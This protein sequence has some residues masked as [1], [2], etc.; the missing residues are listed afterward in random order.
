VTRSDDLVTRTSA[1]D[2]APIR[3]FLIA[4]VRGYTLFT[5][6][7]G[8]EAAAKLAAKFADIVRDV[9]E[10]RGGTL[11]ELRGDEALCVF[12]S[13]REAIRTAVDLQER[14]VEE[15]IDSPE[16]PLTVG[17]GLDAGEAVPVEGGYR[18]GALNLAA[19]LC[20]QA[21]AGEILASREVTH[22][23]RRI[24]GVRYEDRGSLTLKGLSDPVTVVRV[25]PEAGDP[26][27]RLQPFAPP[28]PEPPPSPRRW[29][30]P[31][32]IAAAL[33]S[34]AVAIPL[35]VGGDDRAVRVGSDSVALIDPEDGS[36]GLAE[37]IG[38]RP[39]AMV[40]AFDSVWVIQPDRG[41]VVRLDPSDGSVRDTIPVGSSPAALTPGDDEI[42]VTNAADGTVSRIDVETNQE[43]Q[44]LPAGSRPTGIATGDGALWV[45][46]TT[47]A[48]VLRLDPSGADEPSSIPVP[49]E[50]AGIAWTDNGI[51]V[52]FAPDGVARIDPSNATIALTQTVGNDP[53][54]ILSAH[55]SIWVA[56]HLDGTVHRIEPSSGDVV[57]VIPVGDG[58]TALASVSGS[59]WVA[60]E[61][62]GTV[63]AIA[64][65]TNDVERTVVLDAA[66]ASLATG[67][68]GVWVAVGASGR[69]HRGGTLR[70][71][72]HRINSLDPAFAYDT[73]IWQILTITNDG[74]LGYT[75]VGGHEGTTLVPNL[76]SALPDVSADGLTYRFPLR[77]GI[78]YSTGE[79]VLPEDFRYGLERSI[80][81]NPDA[82]FMFGAIEDAGACAEAGSACDL[83]ESILVD[84]AAITIRLQ[85]PDPDLQYKLAMPFAFPM[86]STVPMEDQGLKPLPA[87]G[88]YM[89]EETGR[90]GLE[91]VRNPEFEQWSGAAQPD[92]F[93]DAISWRF[94]G[95]DE[96]AF[97]LL[98]AESV[99]WTTEATPDDV[100]ALR[101]SNPD[102]VVSA[103]DSSV[104]FVAFDVLQTPFDDVRVRQAVNYAIDRAHVVD[105]LG[106]PT[107][108]H[109]TCQLVPPSI[110]GYQ[111]LCPYTADA[112]AGRWSS[113]DLERARALIEAA[114]V[115]GRPVTVWTPE[116]GV[117]AGT[118]DAMTYVADVLTGLGMPAEVV[119]IPNTDRYFQ[120]YLY[121]A[122]EGTAK[123]PAIFLAGWLTD[124]P[125]ASNYIEPQFGCNGFAN[126]FGVCDRTLERLMDEAK[127]LQV[128]D[129]GA[130]NRAWA[131]ADRRLVDQAMLAPLTNGVVAY[132]V[133]E[134]VG[135]VQVHPLW[136]L[137][138]SRLWVQ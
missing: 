115:A 12:G 37:A 89:V 103:T 70:I 130:A 40:V 50:P 66:V 48:A 1:S 98:A 65:S 36:V 128:S 122:E 118:V 132:P 7:R 38:Y 82:A 76:A 99:D 10:S 120:K 106:G 24:D 127:S 110:P 121:G 102:Q 30:V 136:S 61:Y 100:D 64:P 134:R 135:N 131:A 114:G 44:T 31:V 62:D 97:D 113:P 17:I 107:L 63:V 58:P 80:A 29:P 16:L 125:T 6:E 95:S 45:A 47:G 20:G 22:L 105:L 34:V 88:P 85:R 68:D 26:V 104:L 129:L 109:L 77:E 91:L 49:G 124:F 19:R 54:A 53:T 87:T 8:D 123:H 18:G 15:T 21:R 138:L 74:L 137:L 42:W 69:E 51:W 9:V 79:P 55:G 32:A 78:R 41:R 28:A 133:S 27:E 57:D 33:A 25:V 93:V 119:V 46:D 117:P 94:V 84:G 2:E 126:A 73:Y 81:I 116:N 67:G 4:D 72:G 108:N 90:A 60:N 3:T 86:P 43:S 52:S 75:R 101:A 71:A 112:K 23:A 14:F 35:L 83:S 96:R 59:I 39:G 5:Q 92:G 56:N 111:P 13:A 11:L